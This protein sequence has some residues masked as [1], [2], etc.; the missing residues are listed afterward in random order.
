LRSGPARLPGDI[1]GPL[2]REIEKPAGPEVRKRMAQDEIEIKLMTPE[3]V[4]ITSRVKSPGGSAREVA[5][6]T[7]VPARSAPPSPRMRCRS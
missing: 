3:A 4:A 2:A 6:S 5:Q 7:S 1:L